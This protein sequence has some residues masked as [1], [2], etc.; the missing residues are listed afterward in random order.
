METLIFTQNLHSFGCQSFICTQAISLI[1][2]RYVIPAYPAFIHFEAHLNT[3]AFNRK[4]T[5]N[6]FSF[7]LKFQSSFGK[8]KLVASFNLIPKIMLRIKTK[9]YLNDLAFTKKKGKLYYNFVL[10]SPFWNSE[11]ISFRFKNTR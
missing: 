4:L 6:F 11:Y 1:W 7:S 8:R 5:V 3:L 2:V 9:E 10:F